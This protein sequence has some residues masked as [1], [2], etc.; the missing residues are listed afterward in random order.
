MMVDELN[1]NYI[2]FIKKNIKQVTPN[3]LKQFVRSQGCIIVENFREKPKSAKN[4]Q[5]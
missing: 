1:L 2:K 5:N 4:Q 3:K